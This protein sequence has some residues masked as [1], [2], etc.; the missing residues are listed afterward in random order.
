[1]KRLFVL[2]IA[3]CAFVTLCS[4]AGAV[5]LVNPDGT[6]AEPHQT[7]ADAS[8]VPTV[9]ETLSVVADG[10]FCGGTYRSCTSEQIATLW[11]PKWGGDGH[12]REALYT[13]LG[14]RFAYVMP[15]WKQ[16]AFKK[17]LKD[18]RGWREGITTPLR[19]F[20]EIYAWCSVGRLPAGGFYLS[21]DPERTLDNKRFRR[22]CKLI[23]Q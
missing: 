10:A 21:I 3:V 15:Q 1:M 20:S 19:R 13:L 23:R 2:G 11:L 18:S 14:L 8:K 4:P 17:I 7:W 9:D 16:D 22:I 5:T 6:R 12:L